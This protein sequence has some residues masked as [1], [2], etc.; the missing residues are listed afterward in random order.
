MDSGSSVL[1]HHVPVMVA[2]GFE[3]SGGLGSGGS[4]VIFH[5]FVIIWF[6]SSSTGLVRRRFDLLAWE[7]IFMTACIT[8]IACIVLISCSFVC[9]MVRLSSAN[10]TSFASRKDVS[11]MFMGYPDP[12]YFFEND[13]MILLAIAQYTGW[14][15]AP[16][17][18]PLTRKAVSLLLM[19]P[20]EMTTLRWSC[21]D[22]RTHLMKKSGSPAH[23]RA[24]S[25][26]GSSRE[27]KAS[28][29]S[30]RPIQAGLSWKF[31]SSIMNRSISRA[32][33]AF[34]P[35][36]KPIW[37]RSI[38]PRSSITVRSRFAIL[39]STARY[40]TSRRQIGLNRCRSLCFALRA[41]ILVLSG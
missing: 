10:T 15:G 9:D 16:W 13:I 7:R 39:E 26:T 18:P 29:Q 40:M 8:R 21:F 22:R 27:S 30:R 24:I 12:P 25:V 11:L 14:V 2:A 5:Q 41:P 19:P 31:E 6:I 20:A 37:S 17:V 32:I 35:L 1:G 4:G 23:E 28:E 33:D 3:G 38:G 34:P 36:M